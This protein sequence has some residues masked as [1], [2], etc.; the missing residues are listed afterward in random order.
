M[1]NICLFPAGNNV[2]KKWVNILFFL[3]FIKILFVSVYA[4]LCVCVYMYILMYICIY[5]YNMYVLHMCVYVCSYACVCLS[6][7]VGRCQWPSLWK[8][9]PPWFGAHRVD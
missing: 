5:I 7:E 1:Y 4:S 2:G 3:F 8:C 9:I 6:V